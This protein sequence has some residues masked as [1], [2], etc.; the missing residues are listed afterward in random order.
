MPWIPNYDKSNKYL[1]TVNTFPKF[2]FYRSYIL[3]YIVVLLKLQRK[4]STQSSACY[5]ADISASSGIRPSPF[6][7]QMAACALACFLLP[8]TTAGWYSTLLTN[9]LNRNCLWCAGPWSKTNEQSGSCHFLLLQYSAR[10]DTG[11]FPGKENETKRLIY[12]KWKH[13]SKMH[14]AFRH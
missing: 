10:A 7:A 9:T 5:T 13:T 6:R 12:L 8:H 1:I 11:C 4:L 14:N 3:L 2:F